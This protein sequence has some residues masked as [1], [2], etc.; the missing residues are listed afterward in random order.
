MKPVRSSPSMI[1]LLVATL[2]AGC[3]A[4][5]P[6]HHVPDVATGDDWIAGAS[7]P[8]AQAVSRPSARAVAR[9]RRHGVSD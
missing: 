6:E 4:V 1:A 3:A 8:V 9:W 5:G 7:A 2:L